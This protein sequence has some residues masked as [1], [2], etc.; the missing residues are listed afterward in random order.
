MGFSVSID[1]SAKKIVKRLKSNPASIFDHSY[2]GY[3]LFLAGASDQNILEWL[4]KNAIALDSLTSEEIAYVIFAKKF[5]I[6]LH[7]RSAFMDNRQ[8]TEIGTINA[9]EIDDGYDINRLVKSGKIWDDC[10]W[11]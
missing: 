3:L 8:P 10:R 6:R 2:K 1:D 9:D 5:K 11:R 7:C 4:K